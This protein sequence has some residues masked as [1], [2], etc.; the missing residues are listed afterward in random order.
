MHTI[1]KEERNEWWPQRAQKRDHNSE[2]QIYD[3]TIILYVGIAC[4]AGS[5]IIVIKLRA[6]ILDH[7]EN[8]I[9]H[10]L[11]EGIE[12]ERDRM[13]VCVKWGSQK[14]NYPDQAVCP[15][16]SIRILLGLHL[17]VPI[18]MKCGPQIFMG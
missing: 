1:K 13:C 8:Q 4:F 6:H 10:K 7:V 11:A 3:N 17:I 16:Y 5:F 14:H 2:Q 9:Y 12:I 18:Q 15:T